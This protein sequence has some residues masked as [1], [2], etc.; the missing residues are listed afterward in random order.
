MDLNPN[1]YTWVSNKTMYEWRKFL[2]EELLK[3]NQYCSDYSGTYSLQL[4]MHEG[5]VSRAVVPKS[6]WWHYQ[7]YVPENC[8]LLTPEEHIP[9]S[10]SKEWC[11]QKAFE[12]YG[13]EQVKAWFYGLPWKVIPFRI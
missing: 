11:V 2:K 12:K 5:I 4:Q 3:I 13:E 9:Q 8:F 10:P 7:I 6:I 1:N